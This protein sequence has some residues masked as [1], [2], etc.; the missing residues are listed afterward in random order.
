MCRLLLFQA[1]NGAGWSCFRLADHT[2][3]SEVCPRLLS[4]FQYS[5]DSVYSDCTVAG[6]KLPVVTLWE[7]ETWNYIMTERCNAEDWRTL[8]PS[9]CLYAIAMWILVMGCRISLNTMTLQIMSDHVYTQLGVAISVTGIA[10]ARTNYIDH[11]YSNLVL[12]FCARQ[13]CYS[14]YMLSPVRPSVRLSVRP[15]VCHTGGSVKNGWS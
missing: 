3:N 5:H 6:R 9:R 12:D 7:R 13:L 11:V 15:S 14:A 1:V 8:T 4:R 2:E 10:Q